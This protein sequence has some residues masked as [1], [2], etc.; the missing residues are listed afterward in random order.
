MG[1]LARLS[2]Y[3]NCI[4]STNN[5]IPEYLKNYKREYQFINLI[6]KEFRYITYFMENE[7]HLKEFK[8]YKLDRIMVY[9]KIFESTRKRKIKGY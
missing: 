6:N 2:N 1:I 3:Q 7:V 5:K 4:K 9:K 8:N